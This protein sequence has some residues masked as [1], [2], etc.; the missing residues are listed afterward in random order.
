VNFSTS[1]RVLLESLPV[2]S[3]RVTVIPNGV[4]QQAGED[5]VRGTEV[6]VESY[7]TSG[8]VTGSSNRQQQWIPLRHILIPNVSIMERMQMPTKS[9]RK[10]KQ[11][12]MHISFVQEI[13]GLYQILDLGDNY[14]ICS[15]KIA[16]TANWKATYRP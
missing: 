15:S 3:R 10:T 12:N 5:P 13:D 16:S 1:Y 4:T 7:V 9:S 14:F 8:Y 11:S 2:G 6:L